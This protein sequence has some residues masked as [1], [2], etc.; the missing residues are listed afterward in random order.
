MAYT[1]EDFRQ[2]IATAVES[3]P[4]AAAAYRAG[5]PRFLAQ[6]EAMASMLSM[7]SQQ[8]D[9]AEAEPFL[10]A[11]DGTVLADAALKG[12]LPLGRSARVQLIVTNPG[13]FPVT[14]AAG[15][16]L[17][18]GRGRRYEIEA[19]AIVPPAAPAVA[20]DTGMVPGQVAVIAVQR[21]V[22]VVQHTVTNSQPF[23]GIELP[24]SPDGLIFAG[25]EVSSP[26]GAYNYTPDFANVAPGQRVFHVETDEYRRVYIRFGASQGS[27]PV[28]G[29]QPINGEVITLR[30]TECAGPVELEA[31]A[32][33]G[34]EYV[35]SAAETQLTLALDEVL[36]EGQEPLGFG[37]LRM[38]SRYSAL[39]DDN[40]VFLADFD[41]L[42]RKK[43]SGVEFL[44]VWN[45]QIEE[46]VRGP[47]V[48]NINKLF[49]AF[50]IPSQLPATSEQQITRIIARA[51]DSYKVVFVER[52]EI[53]IPVTI[54]AKVA[55]VHDTG[56]V[57]AQIRTALLSEYGRGSV[58]ASQGL[59]R[60]FRVQRVNELL[61]TQ[62]VALQDQ[63][64]DFD[65]AIGETPLTPD[66]LPE[67]F[68]FISED[69]LSVTVIRL[70]SATGLWSV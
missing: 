58:A 6:L 7:L 34:I 51:D 56:D 29:R 28:V 27:V 5:D 26:T 20:P 32:E 46:S 41:F 62:V 66:P 57:E 64:S 39:H 61:R 48:L 40:A 42:L 24:P 14:L 60:T 21:T 4:A 67:D 54:T 37:V 1:L 52:R 47:D 63:I 55:A 12:I 65:L 30:V 33:L 15:R 69:S 38:L 18:D 22:R 19:P 53:E 16:G 68:R 44:S 49:V 11:R 8:I 17:L 70:E 35:A 10:K 31:G 2:R 23:Y 36:S 45:E 50:S 13:V 3:R 9:L 43:L 59:Q 25:L